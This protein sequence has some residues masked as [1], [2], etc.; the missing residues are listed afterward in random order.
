MVAAGLEGR[1]HLE[2][3]GRLSPL[4]RWL[5]DL[6]RVLAPKLGDALATAVGVGLV[7]DRRVAVDQLLD[8]VHDAP[9]SCCCVHGPTVIRPRRGV[10]SLACKAR[11]PA[12][13]RRESGGGPAIATIALVMVE[14]VEE[15]PTAG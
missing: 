9:H 10:H 6:P 7:P 15:P 4:L 3:R 13:P 2:A 12:L 1:R 8:V 5:K 14:T 11:A